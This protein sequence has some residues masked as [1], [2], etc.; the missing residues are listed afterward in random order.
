MVY[1]VSLLSGRLGENVQVAK[2][3]LEF[4][5]VVFVLQYCREYRS[6]IS[7]WPRM[8]EWMTHTTQ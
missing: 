2:T 7:F 4:C 5:Q 3:Y 8:D 1:L 6:G